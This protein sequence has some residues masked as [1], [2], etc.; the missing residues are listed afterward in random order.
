MSQDRPMS[1][2]PSG[3]EVALVAIPGIFGRSGSVIERPVHVLLVAQ[4]IEDYSIEFAN[5]IGRY[6]TVTLLV[7]ARSFA[8]LSRFV[9]GEVDLRFLDWPRHRSPRNILFVPSFVRL[10]HSLRPDVVHFLSEGVVWLSF[11]AA[12]VSRKYP[13]VTTIHDVEY[14]PG[15]RASRRIPLSFKR[16]LLSC[17][18][19]L[20]VHG[21]RLRD[22]AERRYPKLKGRVDVLPHLMLQRYR[23]IAERKA[24][25]RKERAF[26]NILFFGRIYAYKGLEVFIRSVPH[27]IQ[28]VPR[29][30]VIIAG[31]GDKMDSYL[32]IMSHLELFDVRNRYISDDETA[33][34]FMD[35]D[36]VVLPY[37]EASQSGVLA[38]ANAFGKPVVVSDVGELSRTVKDGET[39]MVV[40][41]G[42]ERALADAIVRLA[43]DEGYRLRLGR[44]GLLEAQNT[45][46]PEL[47]ASAAIK[48]YHRVLRSKYP[49]ST[50]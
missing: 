24:L 46:S 33:Q 41:P 2:S 36:I 27:I 32:A 4:A 7:P 30:R 26:I 28:H 35:A 31:Q 40:P 14:H 23:T 45:A 8:R 47:V 49:V 43:E 17:S 50:W 29:I 16:L 12:L 20:I 13:I 22:V 37:L 19:K 5:A 39:G 11:G 15:D 21:P 38:I 48:I 25:Q 10:V 44:A 1:A 18:D 3:L 42:D 34:L 6:A 9:D